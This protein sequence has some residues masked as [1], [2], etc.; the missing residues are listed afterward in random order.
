[1]E[2]LPV[3]AVIPVHNRAGLLIRL[4]ETMRAQTVRVAETIVVDNASTDGARDAALAAGCRIID[5]GENA[6]FARAVNR[7]WKA[8]PDGWVAILNTDVEL[9]PL[10]LENLLAYAE[11]SSFAAGLML[12]AA[13]RGIVDGSYD[14]VSRSG[15][16]WRAG[17]GAAAASAAPSQE[18]A[19]V[20][21]TACIFRR[22]VLA[23]L[24]GFDETFESY[25]EDVDLGLRCLERGFRGVYVPAALAWH[26]GSAT[27][28]RWDARTV[29]LLSRNQL[30]LVAKHFD[31]SLLRECAWPVFIGQLL[32]GLVALRHGAGLSW[33]RGKLDGLRDFHPRGLHSSFLRDFL[34]ASEREIRL[35][36]TDSYWRWYFRLTSP[37]L[38]RPVRR[39]VRPNDT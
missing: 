19:I 30:R 23:Q 33:W 10:W 5:M 18:V 28:G 27:F 31:R 32:W 21:G 7:G 22:A 4:L 9:D 35:R 1:M 15:C 13:D 37:P 8:A 17:S 20:S 36:A 34:G 6:G 11:N 39:T 3:T 16:A 38:V 26:H 24:G 29:R 2:A 12:N 14:L 25:L